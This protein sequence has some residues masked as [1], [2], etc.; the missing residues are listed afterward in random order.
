[1]RRREALDGADLRDEEEGAEEPDAGD[2][3]QA[4]D[5]RVIA[6]EPLHLVV[7]RRHLGGERIVHPEQAVHVTAERWGEL[8]RLQ[9]RPPARP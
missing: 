3:V 9:P 7:H 1:M 8:Y 5:H 2:G 6:A 4:L